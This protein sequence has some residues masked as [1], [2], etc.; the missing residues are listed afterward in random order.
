MQDQ[1]PKTIIINNCGFVQLGDQ[2]NAK[3]LNDK[4]EAGM[5]SGPDIPLPE[6][7]MADGS[8]SIDTD[9]GE[10]TEVKEY[11]AGMESGPD[12]P[13][14]KK[15]IADDSEKPVSSPFS[16][17][18]KP[19]GEKPANTPTLQESE[20]DGISLKNRKVKTPNGV[21]GDPDQTIPLVVA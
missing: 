4:Y 3:V 6:E 14:L 15:N 7:N 17:G 16:F 12:S 18:G 21:H 19:M 2:S 8:E 20:T 10:Q 1:Q 11:E 13:L 5:K 9:A